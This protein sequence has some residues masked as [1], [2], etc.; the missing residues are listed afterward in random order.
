MRRAGLTGA[1]CTR[2]P[3][4]RKKGLGASAP[5]LPMLELGQW[6]CACDRCGGIYKARQLKRE[7]N[8]LRTCHGP[9][10]MGCWEE[11]HPLDYLKG[12]PDRQ[13]PPWVRPAAEE[14]DVSPGSGNEITAE[15]L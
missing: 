10:T 9:E 11:R 8:G 12:K 13:A 6:K 4:L 5:I 2:R 3:A 7:W 15:D 1:A 14:L